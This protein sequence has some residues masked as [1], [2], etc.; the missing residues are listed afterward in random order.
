MSEALRLG[1]AGLGTVGIGVL[2]LLEE[3]RALLRQRCGRELVVSAV[4]SRDPQKNRGVTLG[5]EI[6]WHEDAC[7]L[8][9]AANVDVVVELIGGSDGI[10]KQVVETALNSRKHVVTANK[11]LLA[12][13]GGALAALAESADRALCYEAAVGGG[14]PVI[15]AIREGLAANRFDNVYGILNGTCNYILTSMEKTGVD[16]NEALS[17]AQDLGYAE[18]DPSFDIDGIDTAHK[19]SLLTS[20]AYGTHV[21]YPSVF[22]EGISQIGALDIQFA[23][24]FGYRI[25][26]LGMARRTAHGVEQ[27]VHPCMVPLGTPIAEVSGVTNAVVAVGNYAGQ[28]V[29][30]G[31]G[32]GAGPTASAVIADII[33]I[34]RKKILPPFAAPFS[35]L[36][37]LAPSPMELRHGAYYV[38]LTVVDQ[39]GVMAGITAIM[40]EHGVSIDSII[41]RARA[42]GEGVP[43][44]IITHET[45]E[46]DMN[47]VLAQL[48]AL[49][50]MR[51]PPVRIR[52]EKL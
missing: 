35:R 46:A 38:R 39:P 33:D 14:I 49:K 43:V 42:P 37:R 1:I 4:S 51:E 6:V 13:H 28:S 23:R 52:I 11:A 2:S 30:E 19:L 32:A 10:A 40:A 7:A 29:F 9:K 22:I 27:R 5:A 21:D 47:R 25:K 8:A 45:E 16:F 50:Q 26:L 15:K 48:A 18:A 24:E 34:A 12:I 41:Q 36:E 31:P 44:V 17:Q 3:Q 20:L